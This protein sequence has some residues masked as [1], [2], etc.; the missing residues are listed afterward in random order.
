MD[1]FQLECSDTPSN[2]NLLENGTCSIGGMAGQVGPLAGYYEGHGLF[3][4]S[5]YAY[6]IQVGG[7]AYT[8]SCAYQDVPITNPGRPS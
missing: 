3:S 5:Q 7:D 1:D 8:E 6:S 4:E 2:L